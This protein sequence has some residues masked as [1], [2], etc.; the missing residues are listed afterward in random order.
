LSSTSLWASPGMVFRITRT[1][2]NPGPT[3]WQLDE[4]PQM[5][6]DGPTVRIAA[7]N[8]H[9]VFSSRVGEGHDAKALGLR[10]PSRNATGL[11]G[12]SSDAADRCRAWPERPEQSLKHD[13]WS[14]R[15]ERNGSV[16]CRGFDLKTNWLNLFAGAEIC[17]SSNGKRPHV[18]KR[19]A[20]GRQSRRLRCDGRIKAVGNRQQDLE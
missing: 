16:I 15:V 6:S 20:S 18:A 4:P 8:S 3:H 14:S 12:N 13:L 1:E 9:G 17:T 11:A 2:A 10:S 19:G 7:W 5:H